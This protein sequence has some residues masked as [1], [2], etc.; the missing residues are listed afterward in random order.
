MPGLPGA[1][2][3]SA[4]RASVWRGVLAPP[5][6]HHE[7]GRETRSRCGEGH[8]LLRPGPTRPGARHPDLLA[9]KA[10]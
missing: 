1:T 5:C 3:T 10:T 2:T 6:A 4:L 9:K 7:D 8:E